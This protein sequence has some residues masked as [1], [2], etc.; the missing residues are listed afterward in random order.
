MPVSSMIQHRRGTAS[1][2]TG[3]NP[4]LADGELG[5]EKDTGRSKIGNE[6]DHWIDL[7]YVDSQAVQ[8]GLL[9]VANG[10]ATLGA[11]GKL[12]TAQA[13]VLALGAPNGIA[14]LDGAGLLELDQLGV[15]PPY[16]SGLA[17]HVFTAM[18]GWSLSTQVCT[19]V[20]RMICVNFQ[21]T[22]IG[23]GIVVPATGDVSAI[24]VAGIVNELYWPWRTG[25][26]VC[27]AS[28][29]SALVGAAGYPGWFGD[30]DG[31]VFITPS[32]GSGNIVVSDT[33]I[34]SGVWMA[35]DGQTNPIDNGPPA[36]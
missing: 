9:G 10:V 31:R 35:H 16:D 4:V 5:F 25:P 27:T 34:L 24:Q 18:A 28:N 8:V 23:G 17:T 2:W 14:T 11:G 36:A 21:A 13:P 33:F 29:R 26:M 15:L 6:V 20:G 1:E 19:R 12:S 3:V 32:A 7:P 30:Y 22:Y